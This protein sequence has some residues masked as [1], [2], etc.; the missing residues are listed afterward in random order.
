MT[1]SLFS[2]RFLVSCNQ[3][4]CVSLAD[5]AET[6][7][8][9]I[10]KRFSKCLRQK[11]LMI[12]LGIPIASLPECKPFDKLQFLQRNAANRQSA[13]RRDAD[14]SFA[15]SIVPILKELPAKKNR[16]AKIEIQQVLLKYEFDDN[17]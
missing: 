13:K 1:F 6:L 5:V 11:V 10:I 15:N 12:R 7:W 17:N 8:R 4:I 9:S 14:E 2:F 16:L 3:E